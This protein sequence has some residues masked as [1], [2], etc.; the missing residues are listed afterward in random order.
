M[1]NSVQGK[2]DVKNVMAKG[3]IIEERSLNFFIYTHLRCEYTDVDV[4][5]VFSKKC[6]TFKL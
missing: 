2:R 4:D 3:K 1:H 5:D 6:I